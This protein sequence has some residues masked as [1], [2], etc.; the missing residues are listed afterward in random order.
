MKISVLESGS[1]GTALAVSLAKRGHEVTLHSLH[2]PR[3]QILYDTHENPRLPGVTLPDQ[4]TFTDGFS[5]VETA[6]AVLVVTPSIAVRETAKSLRGLVRED[7]VIVSAAKG[8]ERGSSMRMSEIIA[9]EIGGAERIAVLSGPSHAEEVARGIPTGCV[10]ASASESTAL[11][12]QDMLMSQDF[13]VYT[14][15][16]VIGV[17]LCG[18]LKNVI[19]IC[20]GICMG[21][22]FGDNSNAMMMTRGLNEMANLCAALG[23]RKETSAGL[24]GVGDLFVTCTSRHSRNRTAGMYIGQGMSAEEATAKVGAIVEGYYATASALELSRKAG[25]EMPIAEELGK[26]LFEGKS[27]RVATLDLMS[28][29]RRAEDGESWLNGQ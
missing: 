16:D 25:V 24:A 20:S 1:W 6:G 27:P 7:A 22:G 28:R 4:I 19:A 26:I 23:G 11:L 15:S 8:I 3:S 18:A 5:G 10:A 21:L 29:A 13:R 17:E 2:S 12:V 14:S 9:Q